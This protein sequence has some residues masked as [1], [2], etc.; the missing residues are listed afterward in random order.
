MEYS[1]FPASPNLPAFPNR[2]SSRYSPAATRGNSAAPASAVPAHLPRSARHQL[3]HLVTPLLRALL[4]L[5]GLAA[6]GPARAQQAFTTFQA[7]S[8]VVGQPNFTSQ[9]T[10]VSQS[11]TSGANSS[12]ISSL[13][14]LAVGSQST[15][16]VLLWNAVPTVNGQNADVVVG[17]TSFTS[18]SRGT[19]AV[20]TSDIEGV[21]FSPD[22]RKLLV[23]DGGNNRMLIWNSIPTTNGQPADVVIGQTNFTTAAGG[24]SATKLNLPTGL[25][26][27]P[28]GRLFVTDRN[29]SRVL[30]YNSIPITNGA[31]A[32]VV[33]GQPTMTTVTAGNAASRLNR[34]WYTAL[35]P[36]GQLLVAEEFNNRVVVFDTVPTAN[37]VAADVV[38]GQKGFGVSGAG[39]LATLL[40]S[41]IGVAVSA[42]GQ[43]AIG[44]FANNRVLVYDAVPAVV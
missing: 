42:S 37:G 4:L 10:V 6:A 1:S 2:I 17:E 5:S 7:A 16:R 31:A 22:G 34:P 11:V 13:G 28:D 9:S 12:A 36:G 35:A 8:L 33:I 21:A 30:L 19:T 32:N 15:G 39:T 25:T 14:V 44:E 29:N 27:A 26:V 40:R 43:V 38:I 18:T 24:V 23:S 3:W 41:P 20:L